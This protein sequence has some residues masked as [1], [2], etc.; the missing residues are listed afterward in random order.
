MRRPV[1]RAAWA[2]ELLKHASLER[3]PGPGP[4][5]LTLQL[6]GCGGLRPFMAGYTHA[7]VE[8]GIA[9]M[10]VDSFAPRGLGRLSASA[11]VCTG[12]TLRGDK[13]AADVYALYDWARNESWVD[14]DRIAFAGWSHGAWTIMDALALGSDAPEATGLTDLPDDPLKGLAAT[15]LIYAYAGYPALTTGRG[16][17]PTR[18][19]VSALICERDQVVGHRLPKRAFDRLE[20]DGVAVERLIYPDARHAFD[21]PLPN[22]PRSIY[23]P[24]LFEQ[25]KAWYVSRLR[26]D[27]GM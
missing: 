4:H 21:D 10:T 2:A 13:R 27:F 15:V 14:P 7:A 18:P 16:W 1:T 26:A 12:L 17:G 24:D 19:P 23:R 25:T 5:P 9:A 6:H 22:D 8:G 11:L 3:P 20:R